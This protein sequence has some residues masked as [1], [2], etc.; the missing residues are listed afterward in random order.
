MA[1]EIFRDLYVE[2]M[3]CIEQCTKLLHR[4]QYR[5]NYA[6]YSFT[7]FYFSPPLCLFTMPHSLG[8]DEE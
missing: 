6:G 4:S 2:S 3:A 7:Y 8:L 1:F 5:P